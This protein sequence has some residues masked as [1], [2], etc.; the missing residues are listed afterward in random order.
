MEGVVVRRVLRDRIRSLS[1]ISKGELLV[2]GGAREV[3]VDIG[4]N[5]LTTLV[6]I[7]G[8]DNARWRDYK[9]FK[10]RLKVF[11]KGEHGKVTLESLGYDAILQEAGLR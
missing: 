6:P 4:G 5:K 7:E 10:G 9:F 8:T 1:D 3:V 2:H 11:D